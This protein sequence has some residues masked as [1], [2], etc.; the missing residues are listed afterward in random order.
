MTVRTRR[1]VAWTGSAST[2]PAG[3]YTTPAGRT[4]IVKQLNLQADNGVSGTLAVGLRTSG[5][6]F[7]LAREPLTGVQTVRLT[8]LW[9]VLHPGDELVVL[10]AAAM[11]GVRVVASGS[12]LLGE[13]T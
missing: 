9:V 12:L 11:S 3:I 1:L 8:G 6:V 13:P 10:A 5:V 2:S 7:Q 4:A